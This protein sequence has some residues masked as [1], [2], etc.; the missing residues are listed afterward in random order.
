[1]LHTEDIAGGEAQRQVLTRSEWGVGTLSSG[2]AADSE[3]LF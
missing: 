3:S 2:L 1:M